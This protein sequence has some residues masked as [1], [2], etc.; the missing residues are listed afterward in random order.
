ME[1]RASK[2][3]RMPLDAGDLRTISRLL[4]SDFITAE[5]KTK[6]DAI[7]T[8]GNKGDFEQESLGVPIEAWPFY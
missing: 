1:F 3:V 6:L 2:E 4:A 5:E 7:R 8:A